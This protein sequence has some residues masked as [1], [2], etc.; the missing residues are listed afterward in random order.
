M[1]L[2]VLS[3]RNAVAERAAA[4]IADV[5]HLAVATRGQFV[6]A[7]S[8]G[9]TPWLMLRLLSGKEIPWQRTHILQV[10]ERVAPADHPDRNLT[11][12]QETLLRQSTLRAEQVH[13]MAV[14]NPNL[15]AAATDYETVLRELAGSP[16]VLDLVHLGLGTDGHTASLFPSDPV[17]EV[18]NQDVS[19]SGPHLGR[20]RMT[21]TLPVLNR[22][23]SIL[24]LVTGAEKAVMLRRLHDGD[25]SV[26]AGRVRQCNAR[27]L[28]DRAAAALVA[29]DGDGMRFGAPVPRKK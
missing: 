2:E 13:A 7:V 21:L 10:D 1:R 14:E 9:D 25:R 28:A 19:V 26:P 4:I 17:L 23:R 29:V 12:L 5:A 16:P 8:G 22:A 18:S 24:W 20:L 11:H 6:F 15:G 3:D 27:I